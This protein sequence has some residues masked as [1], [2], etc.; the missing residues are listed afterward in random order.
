MDGTMLMVAKLRRH[1]EED[2]VE[3]SNPIPVRG[4]QRNVRATVPSVLL[5]L[6]PPPLPLLLPPLPPTARLAPLPLTPAPVH[7]L[8]PARHRA[9]GGSPSLQSPVP[10]LSWPSLLLKLMLMLMLML[11]LMLTLTLAL[12]LMML[13]PTSTPLLR[14]PSSARGARDNGARSS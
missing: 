8:A 10:L 11:I 13:R 3:G 2:E 7:G 1:K 5:R 4:P 12:M 14:T 6:R 9:R